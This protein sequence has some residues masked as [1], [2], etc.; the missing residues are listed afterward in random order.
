MKKTLTSLALAG[1]LVVGG[2]SA[3]NAETYPVDGPGIVASDTTPAVGQPITLTVTVPDGIPEVT[4]SITGAPAGSTLASTVYAASNK[5]DLSVVKSVSN[6]TASAVFTP[7]AAGTF[8]VT[9]TAPGMDP[10]Y[11]DVV[12]GAG[13]SGTDNG[14]DDLA[15]TGGDVPAG[16]IW[17]G[18]GALGLG[19]IAVGAAALRRRA[20]STN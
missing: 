18:V 1:I 9:V 5:I 15:T 19:G 10:M 14:N 20:N 2:A 6:N 11:I 13:T 3:A 8:R 17:A 7:S 12:V 16:V 4:F